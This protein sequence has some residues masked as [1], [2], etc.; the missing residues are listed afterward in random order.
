MKSFRI[1][2]S[3]VY[4]KLESSKE[5]DKNALPSL[6]HMSIFGGQD[7]ILIIQGIIHHIIDYFLQCTLQNTQCS[8]RVNQLPQGEPLQ[9]G[10]FI[11][12]IQNLVSKI[13]KAFLC[14]IEVMWISC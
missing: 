13:A 11:L 5:I 2:L 10:P 4:R 7:T 14:R 8:Q 9:P 6:N 12:K 1:D 3:E